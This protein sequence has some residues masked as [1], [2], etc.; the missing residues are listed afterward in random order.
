MCADGS[1]M[2]A[3]ATSGSAICVLAD[4]GDQVRG[5]AAAAGAAAFGVEWFVC[6]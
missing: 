1:A 2:M 6:C 3:Y 4:D 5:A